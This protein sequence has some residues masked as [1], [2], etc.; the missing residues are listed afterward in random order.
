MQSRWQESEEERQPG[1]TI[2]ST[3]LNKFGPGYLR[4]VF[5]ALDNQEVTLPTASSLLEG[6]KVKNF[7][8][9]RNELDRR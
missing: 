3:R 2:T 5:T 7:E 9:L 8:R 4:L 6:V 1:V